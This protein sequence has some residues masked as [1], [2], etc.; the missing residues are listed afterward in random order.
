VPAAA[1]GRKK[2]RDA[3]QDNGYCPLPVHVQPFPLRSN[4]KYYVGE[5]K[6]KNGVFLGYT[7]NKS[8]SGKGN[9]DIG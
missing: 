5:V 7:I 6:K 2:D 4:I 9:P 3:Q 1:A 8:F